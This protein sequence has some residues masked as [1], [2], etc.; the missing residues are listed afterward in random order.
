MIAFYDIDIML[1]LLKLLNG[2]TRNEP[3]SICRMQKSHNKQMTE[4]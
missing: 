3:M 4:K 2:N 1:A